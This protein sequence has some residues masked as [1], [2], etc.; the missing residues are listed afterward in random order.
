MLQSPSRVKTVLAALLPLLFVW[1]SAACLSICMDG[2]VEEEETPL[3]L[4][5]ASSARSIEAGIGAAH[6]DCLCPIPDSPECALQKSYVYP[7]QADE[8][9]PALTDSASPLITSAG[10]CLA[11]SGALTPVLKPPLQRLPVLRI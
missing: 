7:V 3:F 2:C 10:L 1:V 9:H 11:T 4:A 8:G 5:P 6:E